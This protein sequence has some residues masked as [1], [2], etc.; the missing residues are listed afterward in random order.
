MKTLRRIMNALAVV[1]I[2]C[3]VAVCLLGNPL[4]GL[5]IVSAN[6]LYFLGE[7]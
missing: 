6:L 4:T 1:G 7:N 5:P 3:G 2:L